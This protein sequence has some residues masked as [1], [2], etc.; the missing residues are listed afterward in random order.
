MSISLHFERHLRRASEPGRWA[1]S[2]GAMKLLLALSI[3][4]ATAILATG[5]GSGSSVSGPVQPETYWPPTNALPG[6]SNLVA[7]LRRRDEALI[8]AQFSTEAVAIENGS[9]VLHL[10]Q[11]QSPQAELA[12][13]SFVG[14]RVVLSG[15]GGAGGPPAGDPADLVMG[16]VL[17]KVN[18]TPY[19]DPHPQAVSWGA[20]VLGVL[21]KFDYERKIL[22][23][24]ARPDDW[25]L[26]VI[27]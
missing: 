11:Q 17:L 8:R 20:S 15:G 19:K 27:L 2:D 26:G 18:L 23:I 4:A 13:Q 5:C 14:K 21:K 10:I 25:K 22:W 24:D 9:N 1:H 3:L 7:V 6:G 12:L 16:R